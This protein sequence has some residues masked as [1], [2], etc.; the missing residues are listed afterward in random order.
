MQLW[1]LRSISFMLDEFCASK[2]VACMQRR[3][4]YTGLEVFLKKKKTK[5]WRLASLCMSFLLLNF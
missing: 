4:A 3:L 2:G 5:R 1:P